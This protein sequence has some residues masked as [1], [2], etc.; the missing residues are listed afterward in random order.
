MGR[1]SGTHAATHSGAGYHCGST[2]RIV[3]W[4]APGP[5]FVLPLESGVEQLLSERNTASDSGLLL[6]AHHRNGERVTF[7]APAGRD[8]GA[9]VDSAWAH[10]DAPQPHL[11]ND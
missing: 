2:T 10:H 8:A 11:A 9:R 3:L 5:V 7:L 4:S 1:V 6:P